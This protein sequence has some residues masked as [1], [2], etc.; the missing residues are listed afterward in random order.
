MPSSHGN[1]SDPEPEAGELVGSPPCK[2]QVHFHF[3][4]GDIGDGDGV[5]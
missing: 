4:R 3:M 2:A 5:V 1:L